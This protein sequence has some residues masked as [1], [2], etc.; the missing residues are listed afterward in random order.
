MPIK[1]MIAVKNGIGLVFQQSHG[2]NVA[3]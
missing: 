1:Y 3:R 2:L